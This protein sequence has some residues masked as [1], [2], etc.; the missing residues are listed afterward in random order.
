MKQLLDKVSSNF[1]INIPATT[2]QIQEMEK[3]F[4]FQFPDDYKEFLKFTNGLEGFTTDNYLVLWTTD[5]LVQLNQAYN[6]NEFIS[7]TIIFGSD[8]GEEAFAF[9]ISSSSPTIIKLPF[10]GM[11]HIANEKLSN[12]FETFLAS[13]IK[14]PKSIFKRL[15]G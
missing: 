1:D 11:G 8:G 9:D 6:V 15:F 5:E 14:E 2:G 4:N 10:I 7:N 13:Q 3:H 12:T